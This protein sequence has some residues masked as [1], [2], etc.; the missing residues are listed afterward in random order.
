MMK[1]IELFVETLALHP[2]FQPPL[3]LMGLP[4]A[5]K[6]VLKTS[7]SSDLEGLHTTGRLLVTKEYLTL[8]LSS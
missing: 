1:R 5:I 7:S 4:Q 8:L 6:E 2:L 3:L